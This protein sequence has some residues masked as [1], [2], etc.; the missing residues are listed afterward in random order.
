MIAPAPAALLATEDII[1]LVPTAVLGLLYAKRAH[2]LSHGSHKIPGWRQACYYA[3]LTTILVALL[4]P[5]GQ[6]SDELLYMHMVEHLLMGDIA[7]LLI[8]LGLTGPLLAPVLRIRFFDRLRALT[9]PLIAFPLW[10][11]D[12]YVW[13]LPIFYQAA[14]RHVAI[15]ALEHTMFIALGINMWMCLFGPLPKP[16][17]F[18]N[19]AKLGY[20]VAVRLT[21]TVLGNVFLWSGKA[22]Y[23]F[24]LAGDAAHHINPIADQN[25]AGAVMMVEESFLTLGLFCW[26]FLRTARE[27]EE[28]QELLDFA[29]VQG[30]EVTPERAARAVAAGRGADLRRRLEGTASGDAS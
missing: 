30:V 21:G 3:G 22:F 13:H 2:T 8:V 11:I 5:V 19:L 16:S 15:H 23:P 6:L 28:R 27:V 14:L 17:W 24:Y 4:S 20:I 10:A 9:H 1:Q 26:L 18:G 12:L 29:Q 25:L 7:A